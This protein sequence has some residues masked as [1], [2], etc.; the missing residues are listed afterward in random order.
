MSTLNTNFF[1]Q[2]THNAFLLG[3]KCRQEMY[4]CCLGVAPICSKIHCTLN[5]FLSLDCKF[6]K[7]KCHQIIP[8]NP[9][10]RAAILYSP[11]ILNPQHMAAEGAVIN[12]FGWTI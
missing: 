12:T 9:R 5:R 10:L 6:I 11:G 1:Q 4:W 8:F 7:S 2:R 3:N